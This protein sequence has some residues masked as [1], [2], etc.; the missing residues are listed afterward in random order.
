MTPR[1]ITT[2]AEFADALL[3]SVEAALARDARRLVWIDPDFVQWP[4]DRAPLID[5]L[6]G[7][8]RRPSRRLVLLGGCYDRLERTHPRFTQ[9]RTQW[10]HAIDAREPSDMAGEDLPTLLLDDGPTVLELWQR[11]PPR[12]RAGQDAAAAAAARDRTDAALQRSASA[13]PTRPL[14]L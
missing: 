2:P 11:D 3:A 4:L 10:S 5:N 14:G 7:W 8:L 13:W 1:D 6:G 9:W 12:G